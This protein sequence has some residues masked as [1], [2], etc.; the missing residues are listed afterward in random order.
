MHASTPASTNTVSRTE[1]IL[2]ETVKRLLHRGAVP[3]LMKVCRK[4]Q[5]ADLAGIFRHITPLESR[6]LYQVLLTE[7]SELA[8]EVLGDME[9]EDVTDLLG[10]L[11]D[12]RVVEALSAVPDEDAAD[13]LEALPADRA[14]RVLELMADEDSEGVQRHLT[15][16]EESAG[17]IMSSDFL[18]LDEG[19]TADEAIR[20]IQSSTE[21]QMAFYLYVVDDREHL[22][23]VISLRKLL[24]V[25]PETRL[26]DMIGDDVISVRTW[27]DREHAARIASRYDLLAVP[28]V[29][30]RNRLVGIITVDDVFDI[31]REEATEDMLRLAGTSEEEILH[32][33]AFW[34]AR[35]RMPWLLATLGGGFLAAVVLSF[36]E[37]TLEQIVALAMF[38]P[39]VLGMGGNVG[40]QSSTIIVRG[41]ATGRIEPEELWSNLFKELRVSLLVGVTYGVLLALGAWFVF[42]QGWLFASVVGGS[43]LASV[44]V[45]AT[46]GSL[47]PILLHKMGVD[48]AVATGPFVTTSVDLLG[49]L[50]YVSLATAVLLNA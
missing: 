2:L 38:L 28:V 46:V 12:E 5:P 18:A 10:E 34:A 36:Y 22:L 26:S 1:A 24:M 6:K 45:A 42:Q 39:V 30:R 9:W 35:R 40:T 29:D 48:P 27:E 3:N 47:V 7:D 19:L 11:P 16:P 37:H 43:L 4:S 14:R 33:G 31:M 8:A 32:R 13:L 20:A 25:R 15:Y 23:G 44:A 50:T 41:L 21:R 17:R 49:S